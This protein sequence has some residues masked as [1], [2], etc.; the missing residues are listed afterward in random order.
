MR[1]IPTCP[2]AS[3]LAEI[4][5]E[6]AVEVRTFIKKGFEIGS[7]HISHYVNDFLSGVNSLAGYFGVESLYPEKGNIWYLNAGD[8][9]AVTLCYNDKSERFFIA[10]WGDLV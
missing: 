9:Y 10:C 4:G 5:I 1:V 8:T 6:N 3:K 7:G 2:P